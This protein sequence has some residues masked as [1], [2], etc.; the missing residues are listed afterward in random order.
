MDANMNAYTRP[1]NGI[2]LIETYAL[3]PVRMWTVPVDDCIAHPT[4]RFYHKRPVFFSNEGSD[5]H[6]RWVALD[7]NNGEGWRGNRFLRAHLRDIIPDMMGNKE[8]GRLAFRPAIIEPP[9]PPGAS[10]MSRLVYW[11]AGLVD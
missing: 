8:W 6:P 9:P 3:R 4:G 11:L 10:R 7:R 5:L 1:V 2:D